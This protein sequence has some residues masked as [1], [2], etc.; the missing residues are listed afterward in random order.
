MSAILK[1]EAYPDDAPY[2]VPVAAP[3]PLHLRIDTATAEYPVER[4][5]R[6]EA[7][8]RAEFYL[9][10]A[11]WGNIPRVDPRDVGLDDSQIALLVY[12][13]QRHV[14]DWAA[15]NAASPCADKYDPAIVTREMERLCREGNEEQKL[16]MIAL[17]A[18]AIVY[19]GQGHQP[20]GGPA[21][22]AFAGIKNHVSRTGWYSGGGSTEATS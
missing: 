20:Y 16:R 4:A 7:S 14:E 5:M 15:G 22:S 3:V 9:D 19:A 8:R 11:T 12:S 1:S 10:A 13:V 2:D 17:F 21:A 6:D 18:E